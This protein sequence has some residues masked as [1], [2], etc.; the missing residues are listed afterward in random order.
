MK[1]LDENFGR[2]ARFASRDRRGEGKGAGGRLPPLPAS[3]DRITWGV[4]ATRAGEP[5]GCSE[6]VSAVLPRAEESETK[7]SRIGMP[8][9]LEF[10]A[11]AEV[12]SDPIAKLLSQAPPRLFIAWFFDPRNPADQ[13][14]LR[15]I[16]ARNPG[17]FE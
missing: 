17:G 5:A 13:N 12:E 4:L 15:S 1:L 2:G 3:L 6:R 9:R 14:A 11:R 16:L 10:R 8:G 7:A